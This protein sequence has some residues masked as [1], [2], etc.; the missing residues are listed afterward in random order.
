MND[1]KKC[2]DRWHRNATLVIKY[3]CVHLLYRYPRTV[4]AAEHRYI[5]MVDRLTEF[6]KGAAHLKLGHMAIKIDQSDSETG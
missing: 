4:T 6:K 3:A 2:L 5:E 1:L